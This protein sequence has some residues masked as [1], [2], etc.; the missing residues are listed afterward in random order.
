MDLTNLYTGLKKLYQRIQ[1]HSCDESSLIAFRDGEQDEL[2]FLL[3]VT[4]NQYG[5]YQVH[6]FENFEGFMRFNL[7][8]EYMHEY[9]TATVVLRKGFEIRFED[10]EEVPPLQYQEIKKSDVR[11]R[12]RGNWPVICFYRPMEF[13]THVGEEEMQQL[14][15]WVDLLQEDYVFEK[16]EEL[17]YA[18]MYDVP[19]VTIYPNKKQ[20]DSLHPVPITPDLIGT[21]VHPLSDFPKQRL[22]V[23]EFL[24]YKVKRNLRFYEENYVE[25]SVQ[26]HIDATVTPNQC[27]YEL[28]AAT[29]DEGI[30]FFEEFDQLNVKQ[31]QQSILDFLVQYEELPTGLVCGGVLG[32]YVAQ[33]LIPLGR[34]ME[35]SVGAVEQLPVFSKITDEDKLAFFIMNYEEYEEDE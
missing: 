23:P 32:N 19:C 15:S 22:Q 25:I 2:L 14:C 29:A 28:F 20:A 18:K 3:L 33:A 6:F 13:V 26:A 12:G 31:L 5:Y 10:R 8:L 4:A 1:G 27:V 9:D 30:L 16:V 34:E 7:F 17:L 35:F 21:T 24:M 11:F